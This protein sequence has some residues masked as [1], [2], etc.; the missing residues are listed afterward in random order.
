MRPPYTITEY[1]LIRRSADFPGSPDTPAELYLPDA[2]F[3]S[4]KALAAEPEADPVMTYF[5]QK[6]RECIRVKNYVG[7]LETHPGIQLEI[8]PKITDLTLPGTTDEANKTQLSILLRMLRQVRDSPFRQL[9]SAR[10]AANRLPLWEVLITAFLDEVTPVIAQGLQQAYKTL[11]ANQTF[12]RG[13]LQLTQQLRHNACH[14]ERF[15]IEYDERTV[16]VAPNRLLKASLL[17]V[18]DRARTLTNQSRI[19]QLLFALD[20]VPTSLRIADDLRLARADNRL[21]A[22]YASVMRWADVLLTQQSFSLSNGPYLSLALLFPMERVFEEYVAAG[23]R[24]VVPADEL[25]IQES[26]AH[27]VDEHAGAPKFKLRPDIVMRRNGQTIVLD[28]KWK[29]ID[30]SNTAGQYGIDQ[31]DLYQ[32]YAYGKKYNA[33]EL[34]LIYPANA[35][36]RQPLAIFGYEPTLQ[37]HVVPFDVLNPLEQEVEKLVTYALSFR[38]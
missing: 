3:D 15:A 33:G 31:A 6:S 32:L 34:V 38:K 35:R 12:L 4:L 17:Y 11:E 5:L 27:L 9:G 21:F 20:D 23:F 26:S 1:G 2:D 7:L 25:A 13:K 8:L 29:V 10:M 19:R 22:R 36:F 18:A 37:L 24:R 28:T 30:G 16:D 14:A